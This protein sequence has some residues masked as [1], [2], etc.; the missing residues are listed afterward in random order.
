MW[1]TYRPTVTRQVPWSYL[2]DCQIT[3]PRQADR[4]VSGHNEAPALVGLQACS[5]RS[6]LRVMARVRVF[7]GDDGEDVDVARPGSRAPRY[8]VYVRLEPAWVISWHQH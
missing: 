7:L 4:G 2:S 5:N 1:V 6:T 8:S 3:H